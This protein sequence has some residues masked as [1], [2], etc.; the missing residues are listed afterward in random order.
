MLFHTSSTKQ[1]V[2]YDGRTWQLRRIACTK[3]VL[4]FSRVG[5]TAL[6]DTIPMKEIQAISEMT[7][8]DRRARGACP[9]PSDREHATGGEDEPAEDREGG[10]NLVIDDRLACVLQV[11]SSPTN[12]RSR[13]PD[14]RLGA[15]TSP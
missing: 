8:T 7:E 3:D 1:D 14:N 4:D 5:D 9:I 13:S 11:P 10:H 12:P 15:G 2:T 6:A